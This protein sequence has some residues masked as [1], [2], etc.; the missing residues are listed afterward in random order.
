MKLEPLHLTVRRPVSLASVEAWTKSFNRLERLFGWRYPVFVWHDGTVAHFYHREK[1]FRFFKQKLTP[2]LA[3]NVRLFNRLAQQF[4]RDVTF[5]K[6][7]VKRPRPTDLRWIFLTVTRVYSLYLFIVGDSFLERRPEAR[8]L[9]LLYKGILYEVDET[10]TALAK[11]RLRF[12]TRPVSDRTRSNSIPPRLVDFLTDIDLYRLATNRRLPPRATLISRSEGYIYF[13]GKIITN[14]TFTAFC[15]QHRLV[16]PETTRSKATVVTGT[17]VYPGRV[18]GRARIV[19]TK[20][21]A[22]HIRAND[23]LI[24]PMTNV[25]MVPA[26]QRAAA[27]VT[28]EGGITCH[29]AIVARELKKPCI[30]GTKHATQTFK[31]GDQI[32]VDANFGRVAI[33]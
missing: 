3:R 29:A 21:D 33:I 15:R 22:G 18:T 28:D 19:R 30:T 16:Q 13:E 2:R 14:Q 1:D 20:V 23:I 10:I 4:R 25:T 6:L 7:F 9:R 5:L 8:P 32:I 11:R 12:S 24:S 26:M 27:I 31:T 17:C